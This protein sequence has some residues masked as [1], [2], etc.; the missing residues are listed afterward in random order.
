MPT[1]FSNVPIRLISVNCGD[2]VILRKKQPLHGKRVDSIN[3]QF[4]TGAE[5]RFVSQWFDFVQEQ[6]LVF[7]EPK[8]IQL[9]S[10]IAP[11]A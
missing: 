6:N 9:L 3:Y 7:I 10:F 1:A 2:Y 8:K 11:E 5:L 4:V